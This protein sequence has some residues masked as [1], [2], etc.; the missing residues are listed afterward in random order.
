MPRPRSAC[1]VRECPWRVLGVCVRMH[2]ITQSSVRVRV[3]RC[4]VAC[5][6]GSGLGLSGLVLDLG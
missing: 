2:G 4:V 5:G 6:F 3:E 1:L